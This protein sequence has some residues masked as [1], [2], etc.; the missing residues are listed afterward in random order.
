L[1]SSL[2]GVYRIPARHA[3]NCFVNNEKEDSAL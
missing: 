3:S 1:Y 2:T